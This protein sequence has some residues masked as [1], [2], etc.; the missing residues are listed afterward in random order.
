MPVTA[1]LTI[2]ISYWAASE[3]KDPDS[4]FFDTALLV[5]AMVIGRLSG[6]RYLAP[7]NLSDR[8]RYWKHVI[9]RRSN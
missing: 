8:S 4:P 5:Y 2:E 3:T 6:A 9:F 7:R 1:D